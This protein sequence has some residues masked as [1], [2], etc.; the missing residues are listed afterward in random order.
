METIVLNDK[1]NG[2]PNEFI[3]KLLTDHPRYKT[4][5][6]IEFNGGYYG[7]L[8]FQTNIIGFDEDGGIYV[9]WTSYW[10]PIKDEPD[11]NIEAFI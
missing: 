9:N 10:F 11:R 6:I 3:D 1:N 5:Q 7:N 8:R 4:G 2:I